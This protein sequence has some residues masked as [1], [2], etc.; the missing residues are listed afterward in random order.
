MIIKGLFALGYLLMMAGAYAVIFV[1]WWGV[2][3]SLVGLGG[4]LV[5]GTQQR[6]WR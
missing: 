3:I 1:K 2:G 6:W 4:C 5:I